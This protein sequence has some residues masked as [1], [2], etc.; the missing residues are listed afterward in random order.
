MITKNMLYINTYVSQ[1][2]RYEMTTKGDPGPI[3][4]GG[5]DRRAAALGLVPGQH[6]KRRF[7]SCGHCHEL[8][9]FADLASDW[10][11]TLV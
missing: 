10:L 4:H 9:Q 1:I 6:L 5:P 2:T 7:M 8:G 11:Y 3:L